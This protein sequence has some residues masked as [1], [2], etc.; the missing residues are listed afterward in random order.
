MSRF[1]LQMVGAAFPASG[2]CRH[3]G[4]VQFIVLW[5]AFPHSWVRSIQA[6]LCISLFPCLVDWEPCTLWRREGTGTRRAVSDEKIEVVQVIWRC[7]LSSLYTGVFWRWLLWGTHVF[8]ALPVGQAASQQGQ[9]LPSIH[10]ALFSPPPTGTLSRG[11]DAEWCLVTWGWVNSWFQLQLPE[12][13]PFRHGRWLFRASPAA[14][15]PLTT[16]V[17]YTLFPPPTPP[18]HLIEI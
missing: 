2:Q 1:W 15:L 16:C 9:H 10:G 13:W 14:P 8:E 11:Q 5:P 7:L 3:M 12:L 18:L 17:Q 6:G 4:F